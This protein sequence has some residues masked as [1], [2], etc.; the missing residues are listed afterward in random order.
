MMSL[1]SARTWA[2]IVFAASI[3][4]LLAVAYLIGGSRMGWVS[5][6]TAFN[7]LET[8]GQIGLALALVALGVWV[9]NLTTRK[10]SALL[11]FKATLFMSVMV[12]LMLAYRVG[13]PPQPFMNDITTDLD[14]PPAYEAILPLRA[15][16]PNPAVYGGAEVAAN[17][18][19]AH[20]EIEPIIST[21]A[22]DAAFERALEVANGLGWNVVAQ[23]RS[24]GRIEAVDTTPFFRFK[25]DVVIRVR[26]EGQGSRI[27]LRSH[28]RIGLTDLGKNAARIMEFVQAFPMRG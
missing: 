23:D 12:G 27:D 14:D 3:L 26:P 6:P 16:A 22:P 18:R 25:D 20:P 10:G 1:T 2:R 15:D 7:T 24:R 28:S 8:V 13:P 9:W 11:A 4:V 19:Q 5:Y 17:Q 21:L